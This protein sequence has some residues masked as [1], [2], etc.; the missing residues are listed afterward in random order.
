MPDFAY[1]HVPS[2]AQFQKDSSV[3]LAVRSHD[4]IISHIDWL[5]GRYRAHEWKTDAKAKVILCDLFVTTNFWLKRYYEK[6]PAMKRERH[7]AVSALFE[8]VTIE[9]RMVFGCTRAEV[10][11]RITEIF[12]RDLTPEG[13]QTDRA[14]GAHFYDCQALKTLRL[15]FRSGRVYHYEQNHRRG[16]M[17]LVPVNSAEFY[18]AVRAV[19]MVRRP[20]WAPFI[21]T[22]EREFYMS[23]HTLNVPGAPNIFHSAYTGGGTVC[24]A[25]TMLIRSGQILGIRP[26]SGHYKPLEN[27]IAVAITALGMHSVPL[28]AIEVVPWDDAPPQGGGNPT[29][30]QFAQSRLNWAEFC[31]AGDDFRSGRRIAA[32]RAGNAPRN[33]APVVPVANLPPAQH[34]DLYQT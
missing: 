29:A 27:N 20:D 11:Q 4:A 22:L 34:E 1:S 24:A 18:E 12:G 31:K 19:G 21:M 17:R 6:H 25:G 3:M 32:L 28:S 14:K 23:R 30:L 33:N 15:R 7:P 16:P 26:D 9:L 2:A 8:R 5:L 10:G 13:E